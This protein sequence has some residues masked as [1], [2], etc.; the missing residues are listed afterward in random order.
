[1]EIETT[2]KEQGE[3]I[4]DQIYHKTITER[5]RSESF[6]KEFESPLINEIMRKNS[7]FSD[8]DMFLLNRES[9]ITEPVIKSE[10]MPLINSSIKL[11]DLENSLVIE[12]SANSPKNHISENSNSS[13]FLIQQNGSAT[14]NSNLYMLQER[15]S[16][17]ITLIKL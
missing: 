4:E 1:M 10:F 8:L 2:K 12:F 17:K 14:K 15:S 16:T 6:Q 7:N 5:M 3:S 13:S 11:F 9:S